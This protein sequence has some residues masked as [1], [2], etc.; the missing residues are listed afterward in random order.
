MAFFERHHP[1]DPFIR[2]P[3]I[4]SAWCPGCGIGVVVNVFLQALGRSD[5]S[6]DSIQIVWSDLGCTGNIAPFLKIPNTQSPIGSLFET[7]VQVRKTHPG[8]L[9]VLFLS[10]SDFMVMGI[11]RLL[12]LCRSGENLLIL[13]INSSLYHLLFENKKIQPVLFKK[14]IAPSRSETPFNMPL[15]FDRYG[16]SYIARWTPLHC[17]RLRRSIEEAFE[18]KGMSFI[19]IISPCLMPI[20]SDGQLGFSIDRMGS[21]QS[22]TLIQHRAKTEELDT[23][24]EG[25]LLIGKFIDR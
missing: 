19:E 10:D 8:S 9:P 11:D 25:E 6:T 13:Y 1:S 2:T 22:G 23:R 15:L 24:Q 5:K 21:H 7:A 3:G 14:H 16:A 18:K 17:W 4:S 12:Q 20:A